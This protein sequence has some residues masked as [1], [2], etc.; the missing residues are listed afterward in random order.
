MAALPGNTLFDPV[1]WSPDG[2]RL[3]YAQRLMAPDNPPPVLVL[4]DGNGRNAAPY[5]SNAQLAFYGWSADGQH[6]LYA[7]SDHVGIGEVDVPPQKVAIDGALS[8]MQWLSPDAFIAAANIGSTW[9][10]TSRSLTGETAVLATIGGTPPQ[11][12]VWSP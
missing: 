12:D 9:Q 8:F 7:A 11:F 4:A 10:L 6:F 3:A 2:S 5:T 1:Q